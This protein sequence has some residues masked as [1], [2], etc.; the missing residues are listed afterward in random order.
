MRYSCRFRPYPENP[1]LSNQTH[2]KVALLLLLA[3]LQSACGNNRADPAAEATGEG[4]GAAVP[5]TTVAPAEA[6]AREAMV[7]TAN[8]YATRAGITMLEAG[9][10]AVDAAIAAHLVLGP[11]RAP[12]FRHRRRRLSC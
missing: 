8:P 10:N 2:R 12:E 5:S 4:A 9:G 7:T 3:A 6:A 11:G 1:M